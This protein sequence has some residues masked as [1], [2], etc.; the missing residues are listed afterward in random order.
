VVVAH[1]VT[2]EVTPKQAEKLA[3]ANDMGKLSL[4][5]RSLTSLSS[6]EP[7]VDSSDEPGTLDSE[8]SRLLRKPLPLDNFAAETVT[9]LRGNGKSGSV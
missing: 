4:S 3:V 5:L 6:E 1:N 2:L 9:V 8:V 7:A